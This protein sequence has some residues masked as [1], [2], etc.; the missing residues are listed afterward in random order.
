LLSS[1]TLVKPD[2]DNQDDPREPKRLERPADRAAEVRL[3]DADRKLSWVPMLERRNSPTPDGG[4]SPPMT[5]RRN[6]PKPDASHVVV[7]LPSLT[8]RRN[9]PKPVAPS[10][11]TDSLSSAIVRPVQA[12]SGNSGSA[13]P[14]TSTTSP[15]VVGGALPPRPTKPLPL[16]KDDDDR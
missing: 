2:P 8:E 12:A 5:E 9:S 6:S 3:R 10:R 16:P 4:V 13:S 7:A 1:G 14:Q 15:S 11:S